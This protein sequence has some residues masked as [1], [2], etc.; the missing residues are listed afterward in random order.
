MVTWTHAAAYVLAFGAAL[1]LTLCLCAWLTPRAWWRRPN[2]R[3]LGV[4]GVGTAAGG[5]LLLAMFGTP[6]PAPQ[7]VQSAQAKEVAG[8][9]V[10]VA[11]ARYRVHDALNLRVAGG[12][13][14]ERLL[15]VPAGT[16]VEATGLRDGDWWQ[17]RATVAGKE[18]EGW[19]SSLWLRR[20]DE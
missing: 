2:A 13:G 19:A 17:V 6:A 9:D 10:P 16:R 12:V 15:V 20:A 1:V 7:L 18:I 14:A 3:A 4:L 11:G 8:I 5:T